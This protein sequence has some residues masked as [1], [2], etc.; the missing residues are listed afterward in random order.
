MNDL[1]VV[2][3]NLIP[4]GRT[5][6]WSERLQ[7]QQLLPE[8]EQISHTHTHAHTLRLARDR[9]ELFFLTPQLTPNRRDHSDTR[10]YGSEHSGELKAIFF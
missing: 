6:K 9:T 1:L 8:R 4:W 3:V 7:V 5:E 10:Y 2:K